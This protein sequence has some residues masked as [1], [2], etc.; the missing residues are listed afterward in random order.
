MIYL[1]GGSRTGFGRNTSEDFKKS[2][3]NKKSI[4]FIPTTPEKEEK[5]NMYMSINLNW[6]E[7]IG[8]KFKHKDIIKSED[9]CEKAKQ[10]IINKDIIF[11]MGGDPIS[12][13]KFIRDKKID[14]ELNKTK[15]V[16]IGLSAGALCISDKCIITKDNTFSENIVL[17]GLNLTNGLNVEVH[18]DDSHDGDIFEV[19]KQNLISE[20][21]AI[22][23]Y[24]SI[25]LDKNAIKYLGSEKCYIFR[26]GKKIELK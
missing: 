16:I 14:V 20:V 17:D 5:C 26:D 11:L 6:F 19:M 2:L 7:D 1:L 23:E 18:Y 25:K 13:L 22:P 3:K 4:V 12:Q 21:Y 15:A 8:L 9:T 10:K 24:C